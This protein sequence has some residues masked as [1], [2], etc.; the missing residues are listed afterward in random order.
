MINKP[1]EP[2]ASNGN[3][4]NG[5]VLTGGQCRFDSYSADNAFSRSFNGRTATYYGKEC[6]E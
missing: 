4:H 3:V 6:S 5:W 2:L 1:S